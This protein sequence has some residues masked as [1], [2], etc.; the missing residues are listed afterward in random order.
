MEELDVEPVRGQA[1]GLRDS[2]PLLE[3]QEQLIAFS[4]RI[5]GSWPANS[6]LITPTLT[7][8]PATAQA[9]HSQAGVTDDAV[10]FSA[11]FYGASDLPTMML[12]W[13]RSRSS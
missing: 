7:R 3:A 6:V 12:P 1:G 9:L 2:V 5:L 10:R 11:L 13:S 8:L 4:R